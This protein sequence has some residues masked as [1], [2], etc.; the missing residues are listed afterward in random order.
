MI[1][2]REVDTKLHRRHSTTVD[3]IDRPAWRY[4]QMESGGVNDNSVRYARTYDRHHQAFTDYERQA[5]E[6]LGFL[7]TDGQR[8]A[9]DMGCGTG[10]FALHAARYYRKIRAGDISRAMLNCA[11][12]KSGR[13]RLTNIAFHRGGFLTGDHNHEDEPVDAIVSVAVLHHPP[14]FWKLVG[15][16]RLA[17]MLKPDGGFNLLDVVFSFDV[18]Q[19]GSRLRQFVESAHSQ[20]GT[21]GSAESQAHL[22][23]EYRTCHWI[24]EDLLERA[25]LPRETADLKDEFLAVYSCPTRVAQK[26]PVGLDV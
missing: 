6:I 17:S 14:D 9:T 25:G 5:E 16:R 7:G 15:L 4:E 20:V 24:I 13:A 26:S 23:S 12:R 8:T 10:V 22:R 19:Y 1:E 11:R 2:A 3:L 21:P 18:A